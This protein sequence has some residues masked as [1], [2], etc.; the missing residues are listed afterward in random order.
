[1][2]MYHISRFLIMIALKETMFMR[3]WNEAEQK[4][5][6]GHCHAASL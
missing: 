1:M 5:D 3:D 2:K 6:P 4:T